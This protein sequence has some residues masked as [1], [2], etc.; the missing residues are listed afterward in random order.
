MLERAKAA[1]SALAVNPR[2]LDVCFQRQTGE[3]RKVGLD[4]EPNGDLE[5][6]RVE[7]KGV[8]Y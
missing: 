5:E 8:G 1:Q 4:E 2:I 3:Q 6:K 7:E